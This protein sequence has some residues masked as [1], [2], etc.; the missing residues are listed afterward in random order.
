M[1]TFHFRK[2]SSTPVITNNLKLITKLQN[3]DSYSAKKSVLGYIIN[4]TDSALNDTYNL[5]IYY[6]T[7]E[8]GAWSFA[9]EINSLSTSYGTRS[10]KKMFTIPIKNVTNFQL[11][12]KGRT[13]GTVAIND[14]TILYRKIRDI[15]ESNL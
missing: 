13:K 15:T 1:A 10:F 12:I 7:M 5:K 4:L 6:R 14:I 8:N 2:W 11:Q 3:F 9:G